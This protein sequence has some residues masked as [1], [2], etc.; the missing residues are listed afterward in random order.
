AASD[1]FLWLNYYPDL[2]ANAASD[3]WA[4]SWLDGLASA[5]RVCDSRKED[6]AIE[7]APSQVGALA[8]S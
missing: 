3:R 8:M 2:G 1:D 5:L 6:T 7:A 4:R